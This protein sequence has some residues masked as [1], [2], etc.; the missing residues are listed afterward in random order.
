MIFNKT[1]L[2]ATA[3]ALLYSDAAFAAAAEPAKTSAAASSAAPAAPAQSFAIPNTKIAWKYEYPSGAS[4]PAPKPE[5]V[6]LVKENAALKV[7][8][9]ILTVGKFQAFFFF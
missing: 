7:T 5:W 6:A 8:P 4:K 9:N 3:V 2:I 1:I